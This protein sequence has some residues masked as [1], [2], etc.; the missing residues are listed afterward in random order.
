MP[1][2]NIQNNIWELNEMK[3]YDEEEKKIIESLEN[4]NWI[5]SKNSDSI[6]QRLQKYAGAEMQ[7][8]E[9]INIRVSAYDL[10]LIKEKAFEE[11]LPYQTLISSVLHKYVT[12]KLLDTETV[13]ELMKK[14]Y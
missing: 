2:E 14:D 11:G 8:K 9:R 12:G 13:R 1:V 6:A 7:K 10:S 3:Y 5:P 4:E